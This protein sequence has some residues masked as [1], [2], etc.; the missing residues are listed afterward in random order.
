M[1]KWLNGALIGVGGAFC[2]TALLF[3]VMMVRG[4]RA[5]RDPAANLASTG[6]DRLINQYG[7]TALIVELVLLGV[8]VALVIWQDDSKKKK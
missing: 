8:L 3:C 7:Q 4:D 6:L 5:S 1:Q 2:F